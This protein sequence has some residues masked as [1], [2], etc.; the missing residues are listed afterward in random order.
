MT[1]VL[2][3]VSVVV[4]VRNEARYIEQCLENLLRQSGQY[5][6]YEI[7]IADGQSTDATSQIVARIAARDPRVQLLANPRQFVSAGLNLAIAQARGEIIIRAD[8]HTEYAEDY[9]ETCVRE[10][11][12]TGADNVGGPA[13]TRARSYFQHVNSAAYHSWFAVGGA[14]FHDP[15]FSGYVDTVP[16]G[17]WWQR[18]LVQ[19]GLFDEELVRNQDDE[20]NLRI[21]RSGGK[22]WQSPSIRS[23]YYPRST[24]LALYKQYYQYGYWKVRVIRKHRLPASPRH[25][26]PAS[27]VVIA[28][29]LLLLAPFQKIA[30]TTLL[31]LGGAYLVLSVVAAI[32]AARRA[33]R[34]SLLPALPLA[35]FLY[36]AGY[37][38]GF[39]R[40]LLDTVF[41]RKRASLTATQLTR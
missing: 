4:P 10:L 22:I 25:L 15:K 6:L 17:C 20:L 13:L 30:L 23:W 41:G 28:T 33:R 8:A 39:C 36:H 5:Q 32:D 37:G 40:A 29:V 31:V 35:F 12:R 14:R 7:I 1:Q 18:R 3:A 38:L 9:V 11:L 27:A 21:V 34:W 24:P 16:Y 19:L 26:I 2:P